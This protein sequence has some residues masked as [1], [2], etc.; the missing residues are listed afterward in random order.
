M[1]FVNWKKKYENERNECIRIVAEVGVRFAGGGKRRSQNYND[2]YMAAVR[3][4]LEGLRN[5]SR[6]MER[7]N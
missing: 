4:C 6:K 7:R 2:G 3:D 5:D 1:D